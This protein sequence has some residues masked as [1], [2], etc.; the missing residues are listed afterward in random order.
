[1]NF[2]KN[3]TRQTASAKV[4]LTF[5]PDTTLEQLALGVPENFAESLVRFG[6]EGAVANLLVGV[7]DGLFDI[8]DV[9]VTGGT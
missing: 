2:A 4:Y 3:S 6:I 5:P 8:D 7:Y 9:V 1:M